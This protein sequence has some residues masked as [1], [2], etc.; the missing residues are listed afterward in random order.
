MLFILA[1]LI[2]QASPHA[3]ATAVSA[4]CPAGGC[5]LGKSITA[6][7]VTSGRLRL[8]QVYRPIVCAYECN[9]P[10]AL[11]CNLSLQPKRSLTGDRLDIRQEVKVFLIFVDSAVSFTDCFFRFDK[12][13]LA[14]PLHHFEAEL[15][16]NAQA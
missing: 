3:V 12:A 13:N 9:G 1:I 16:F 10:A 8:V 15:V 6:G 11:G 14:N 5:H 2:K 4:Y 7:R